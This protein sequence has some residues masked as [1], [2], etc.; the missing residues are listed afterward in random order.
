MY[1]AFC[2][3]VL[4]IKV[5]YRVFES[6]ILHVHHVS[7][8]VYRDSCIVY[9]VSCIV[10]CVFRTELAYRIA[11]IVYRVSCIVYRVSCIVYFCGEIQENEEKYK[12]E[13]YRQL[14]YY[15]FFRYGTVLGYGS[16]RY[17]YGTVFLTT[18]RA[19]PL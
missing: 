7:W 10:Y 9:R 6:C 11:C 19:Q 2:I 12:G 17:G 8:V 3:L 1:R 14:L 4:C 16:R 5:V 18:G 15:V 13:M